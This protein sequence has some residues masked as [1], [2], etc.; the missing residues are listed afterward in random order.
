MRAMRISGRTL[1]RLVLLLALPALA[2]AQFTWTTNHG[3]ITITGYTGP[4]GAVTIPSAANGW[5][6]TSI[7]VGAFS[8]CWGLTSVTIPDSVA[9]I[10]DDAFYWCFGLA[11]VTIGNGVTNVG[12]EAFLGCSSLIS[13]TMGANVTRIGA[14]AF[15]HCTRLAGVYFLGNAPSL[16]GRSVF[17]HDTNAI[18]YHL[19]EQT[20]WG[21]TLGGLP[22]AP[23]WPGTCTTND[24]A[25]TI[26]RYTGAAGDVPI[27]DTINGLAVTRIGA[28]AFHHCTSLASVT[29]P[30]SVTNIGD[31][32]FSGCSRLTSA[33]IGANVTRVGEGAFAFC[34]G[35]TTI[36]VEA[37]NPAYVSVAGV[38]FDKSQTTLMQYPPGQPRSSYLVPSSV[39]N[40]AGA[41]FAG[42]S[43]LTIVV[44]PDSVARIGDAAFS[45]CSNL[46]RV[47][48]GNGVTR[49]G[50]RAFAFCTR[51][52]A[53]LFQGVPP[54]FG[55]DVFDGD[56][57]AL[58]RYLM[59]PRSPAQDRRAGD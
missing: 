24:G 48:I 37:L 47:T 25:I 35:L 51:L 30:N 52:A 59:T 53:V 17:Y 7:G 20:G 44:I 55:S 58:M 9:R 12:K 13:V 39:T 40:I 18:I 31:A 50:D 5:P 14:G 19:P 45:G 54:T 16:E 11:G 21:T 42:C 38:L 23:W 8:G 22:V 36:T 46:A 34:T 41:A 4:G 32:A 57:V 3:A 1:L 28:G 2:Q 26:T 49:I 29:I 6:V 15:F 43:N 33:T 56:N 27:P 10:G